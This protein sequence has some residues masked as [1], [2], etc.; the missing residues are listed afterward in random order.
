MG[1][2]HSRWFESIPPETNNY[3]TIAQGT[4]SY[5]TNSLRYIN[6][7]RPANTYTPNIR[8]NVN[9]KLKFGT[10]M[11]V[12]KTCVQIAVAEGITPELTGLLTEFIMR[13]RR[14]TGLNIEEIHY[15][16]QTN[17]EIQESSVITNDNVPKIS[18]PEYHKPK[19]RPHKRYKSTTEENNIQHISSSS[20]TCSYCSEKGHNI[21]GCKQLKADSVGKE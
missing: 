17:N 8:E 4:K 20:K 6:Q 15:V 12:A 1:F 2:I 13:Y 18:N 21:R 14:N 11:S 9:K 16:P 7:M 5:T 19:G 3:I 10:T